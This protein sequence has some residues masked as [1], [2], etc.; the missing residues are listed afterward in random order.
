M[1]EPVSMHHKLHVVICVQLTFKSVCAYSQS[2]QSLS[3]RPEEMLGSWLP[4][5]RPSKTG[6]QANLS[7]K[8]AHIPFCWTPGHI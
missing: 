8:W 7:L 5:E 3:F 2:D 4:I 1:N 6:T